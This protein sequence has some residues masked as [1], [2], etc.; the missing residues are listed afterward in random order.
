MSDAE[1]FIKDII[2]RYG[3]GR[4]N[5][6]PILQEITKKK[7]YLPQESLILL[8]DE[9]DLSA[10]EIYGVAS[11]YSL[12]DF[13]PCGENIIHICKTITCY[14]KGKDEI[15][16]A[17]ENRLKIKLGETTPDMKFSFLPVNCIGWCHMGPA[18][19]I[20]QKVYTELTPEKA[21]AAIDGYL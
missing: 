19:L 10:A 8:A 12:F 14:M 20:N 16:K 6:L 21:V 1:L 7:R 18:M 3:A 17:I 13:K 9:M 5:L 4:E 11:F 15:V 2:R